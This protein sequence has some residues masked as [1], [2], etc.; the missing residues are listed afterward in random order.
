MTFKWFKGNS[1]KRVPGCTN[2]T[3]PTL[4]PTR[5]ALQQQFQGA[6]PFPA[7]DHLILALCPVLQHA[8]QFELNLDPNTLQRL[9]FAKDA[10]R[11]PAH[12][13]MGRSPAIMALWC[14][15]TKMILIGSTIILY[16]YIY[17]YT[18]ICEFCNLLLPHTPS[19]VSCQGKAHSSCAFWLV[20]QGQFQRDRGKI[21]SA[22]I[23][24]V[25][26]W[27]VD[28]FGIWLDRY[29]FLVLWTTLL[30]RLYFGWTS[31]TFWWSRRTL[32]HSGGNCY[33]WNCD[34]RSND[35]GSGA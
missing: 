1:F 3:L 11:L 18:Y 2:H 30:E 29:T 16:V 32:K 23:G 27:R 13:K 4:A 19:I 24:L 28:S 14:I 26:R 31:T 17:I 12:W 6:L 15:S 20:A 25:G 5:L 21:S 33:Q 35:T 7:W 10:P 34:L 8:T 9:Q 22:A